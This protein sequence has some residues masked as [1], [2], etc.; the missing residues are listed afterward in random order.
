MLG[1]RV[2]LELLELGSTEL[3]VGNHALDGLL[4]GALRAG[5][6]QLAVGDGGQATRVAGVA[7]GELLVSLAVGE[8]HLV[9]I[10]DDDIVA[11]VL[12]GGE[13]GLVLPTEQG[14]GLGRESTQ[15]DVGGVDDVPVLLDV[16]GLR[17]VR[18]HGRLPS[19]LLG[20]GHT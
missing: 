12:V 11:T 20:G 5:G 10:D 2:D 14:G 6:Q 7:V 18:T 13:L 19:F 15:D 1:T 16:A 17:C 9:G 3:G 8:S 4:N